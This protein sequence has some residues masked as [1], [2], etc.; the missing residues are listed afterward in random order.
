MSTNKEILIPVVDGEALRLLQAD[1][2]AYYA[3]VRRRLK[4]GFANDD[5]SED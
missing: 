4:F 3:Q 5:E 1:P 2:D